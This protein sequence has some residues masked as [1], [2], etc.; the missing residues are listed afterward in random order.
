MDSRDATMD[1]TEPK[2]VKSWTTSLASVVPK[3]RLEQFF[4]DDGEGNERRRK[5]I[6]FK[7]AYD[8]KPTKG[9]KDYLRYSYVRDHLTSYDVRSYDLDADL[10]AAMKG[11]VAAMDRLAFFYYFD[12]PRRR[13]EGYDPVLGA[14]AKKEEHR[15]WQ[16]D[17]NYALACAVIVC[18]VS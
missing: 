1:E 11:K 18:V 15:K 13:K 3:S 17:K 6:E 4:S 16:R 7:N 10:D 2:R 9:Q 12:E 14:A 8:K 5:I